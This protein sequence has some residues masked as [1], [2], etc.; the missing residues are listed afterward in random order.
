M[1]WLEEIIGAFEFLG[2]DAKYYDLYN[3]IEQNTSRKLTD[4]W[5]AIVRQIIEDHS[6]DAM[7]RSNID[8]FYSVG[9]KGS[10]HWGLRSKFY[11]MAVD[12]DGTNIPE[13]VKVE[14]TRIIRD[15]DITK[16]LKKLYEN[17]CQICGKAI[18]LADRDFSEVHHLQP[19][20][21][22][23]HGPDIEENMMVVCPNHHASLDFKSIF[24]EPGSLKIFHVDGERLGDLTILDG[25]KLNE[26]F[27]KYHYRL[28]HP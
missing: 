16:R 2:G 26:K 19:L 25:H 22:E 17:K 7:F 4:N 3:Y 21:G 6:S 1:T 9:G 27:I 14:V 10:G 13:K 20:G 28:V 23:H 24:V 18:K 11:E 15:T 5:R 12:L 8:I